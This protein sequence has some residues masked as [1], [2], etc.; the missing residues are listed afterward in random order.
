MAEAYS[1]KLLW[2]YDALLML[3]C[4]LAGIVLFLMLF[5]QHPTVRV[6]FQLLL[7]NPLP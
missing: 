5:S 4:G 1:K 6:N 7:L 3:L 2:G